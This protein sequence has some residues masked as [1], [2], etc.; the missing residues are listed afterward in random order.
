MG[1]EDFLDLKGKAYLIGLTAL[2]FFVLSSIIQHF[3][4][5]QIPGP[6]FAKITN[7]QRLYW[8]WTRHAHENHIDLHRKYGKLVR[9]GPNM[10]SIGDATEV[11]NIYR[12]SHP[13]EKV[14][15]SK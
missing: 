7:L 14:G 13:L 2:L 5:Q 8:V 12:M 4:L 10:V 15:F 3:R 9:L 6:F 11:K 1:P